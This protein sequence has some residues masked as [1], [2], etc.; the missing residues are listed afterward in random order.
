MGRGMMMAD[1]MDARLDTLVSAMNKASG[2]KK[3]QAMAAVINELVAQRKT[4][5]AHMHQMMDSGGMRRRGGHMMDTRKRTDTT[6][7]PDTSGGNRR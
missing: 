7:A 6:A 1:S 3:V 5:R 2:D 4:M